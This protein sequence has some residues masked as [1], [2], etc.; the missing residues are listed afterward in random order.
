M[1][2]QVSNSSFN[3]QKKIIKVV[4]VILPIAIAGLFGIKIEGYDLSFLPSV[5][6][7]INGVTAVLLIVAVF[8]AKKKKIIVHQALIKACMAL[9]F[10]FLLLYI[11]Y[12]GTSG[13][14]KFGGDI[15]FRNYVYFPILITH[16]I[17]SIGVVPLVLFSF[18][19][20]SNGMVEEHRKLVKKAFPIWLYVAISGVVVYLMISPYY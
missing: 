4:S 14:T 11:T 3:K 2:N 13:D 16:I 9:S 12:H 17:L 8:F 18:L 19:Y 20:G 5:Y 15:G 7:T 6:A 1:S 10:I